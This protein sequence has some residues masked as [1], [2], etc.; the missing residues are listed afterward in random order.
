M[1]AITSALK[2]VHTWQT[3]KGLQ[4]SREACGGLG[5]SYYSKVGLLRNDF[6]VN[7]TWEGDNNV[8]LQQTAKYL[9]DVVRDK[10]KGKKTSP[11]S[12]S[13]IKTTP[14]EGEQNESKSEEEFL[15]FDNLLFV[16]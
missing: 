3:M 9:I 13:W 2:A 1:H 5:Y 14:V 8:L 6:D 11:L 4:E 10:L 12:T 15:R 7:Q 16:F